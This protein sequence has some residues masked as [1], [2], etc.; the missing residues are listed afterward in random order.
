MSGT[1]LAQEIGGVRDRMRLA[2]AECTFLPASSHKRF[3]RQVGQ[4]HLDKIT[5]KQWRHV[6]RLAW[7]YRRQMP[8]DL[9]P[10]KDAVAALD[11]GWQEQTVAGISVMVA[12]PKPAKPE[13]VRGA[14]APLP[15]FGEP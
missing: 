9:V 12:G 6:I 14:L 3:A 4:M 15:L 1:T 7:R 13:R 11:A 5:E 2:L 10:S 8:L